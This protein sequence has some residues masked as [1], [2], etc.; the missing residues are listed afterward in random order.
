[1]TR[2]SQPP[3][4]PE[5]I[6]KVQ[7]QSAIS[8]HRHNPLNPVVVYANYLKEQPHEMDY[9]DHTQTEMDYEEHKSEL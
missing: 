2:Q 8:F 9:E 6:L 7:L 1:M 4:F 5:A 3:S